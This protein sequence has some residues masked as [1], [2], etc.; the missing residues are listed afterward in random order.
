MQTIEYGVNA[1]SLVPSKVY[2]AAF[3][4]ALKADYGAQTEKFNLLINE[5]KLMKLFLV[6]KM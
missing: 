2:S 6:L 1:T 3:D 4:A 5:V